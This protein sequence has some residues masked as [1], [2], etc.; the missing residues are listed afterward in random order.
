MYYPGLLDHYCPVSDDLLKLAASVSQPN[1]TSCC[2]VEEKKEEGCG[3]DDGASPELF[4]GPLD[5]SEV[6]GGENGG[7]LLGSKLS[8]KD[9]I[10]RLTSE[11][12]L[13]LKQAS[14]LLE[15]PCT[16]CRY[17]QEYVNYN[18]DISDCVRVLRCTNF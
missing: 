18:L 3:K 10:T 13:P 14:K 12:R 7:Q 11:G 16:Y 5:T 17:L 2:R 15:L 1:V 8:A 9:A 6:R 4:D